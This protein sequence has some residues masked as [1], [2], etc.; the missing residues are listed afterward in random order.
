V[1]DD[2][3]ARGGNLLSFKSFC[4]GLVA[5]EC[6]DNPWKYKFSWNPRNVVLAG[7][8]VA[9]FREQGQCRYVPYHQLFSTL[10]PA[11]VPGYGEFEVYPNRDSLQYCELY[12]LEGIPTIIRGTMRRPGYSA[13]WDVFVQLG[14]TDDSFVVENSHQLS[15]R[16][17]I[18]SFLPYRSGMT[19]KESLAR[20]T[21]ISVGVSSLMN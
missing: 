9:T 8:G 10:I 5:P 18:E 13:A 20:F 12:G 7:Q 11:E 16:Q 1:I 2:I 3:K 6:D 14:C 19:V 4:G 15:Y 17:F 21:G